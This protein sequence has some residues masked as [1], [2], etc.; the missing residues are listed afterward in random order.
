M[1]CLSQHL[2]IVMNS[3]GLFPSASEQHQNLA[4]NP[5]AIGWN[6]FCKASPS[7]ATPGGAWPLGFLTN[8]V[9]INCS[10]DL[11]PME[12][13]PPA[14]HSCRS[15]GARWLWEGVGCEECEVHALTPQASP[16]LSFCCL[17]SREDQTS[18]S[19]GTCFLQHVF[20]IRS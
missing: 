6:S 12:L 10:S 13:F 20:R 11:E 3:Q 16:L 8:R 17:Q 4:V 7:S 15:P 18:E 14:G 2:G 9:S 5:G 1:H 19:T